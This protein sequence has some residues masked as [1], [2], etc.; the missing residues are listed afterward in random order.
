M[1]GMVPVKVTASITVP[2]NMTKSQLLAAIDS[3]PDSAVLSVYQ[4]AGDRPWDSGTTTIKF[5]WEV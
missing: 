3:V 2:S 1:G 4:Y 5:T